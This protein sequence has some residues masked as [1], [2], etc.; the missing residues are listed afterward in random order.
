MDPPGGGSWLDWL[1]G[2]VD[3]ELDERWDEQQRR[4]T[5]ARAFKSHGRRGTIESLR[6]LIGLYAGAGVHITEPGRD[7]S[8]WALGEV[9][10]LG[11]D[12]ML[13]PAAADGAIVGTTATFGQSHLIR[14]E[15][16]GAPLFERLA[17]RFCIGVYAVDAPDPQTLARVAEVVD[18]EKPA[19]TIYDLC[20]IEAAMRV[21]FQAQI[22]IDTIVAGPPGDFVTGDGAVLGLG[23]LLPRLPGGPPLIGQGMT[24][25]KGAALV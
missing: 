15:D 10:T 19:H 2:W 5:V 20:T 18:R 23:T 14:E 6:E 16:F 8:L 17:H 11:F 22:G 21:G 4:D 3:I 12:S 13:A 1:A 24:L 25:G 7:V 9:S